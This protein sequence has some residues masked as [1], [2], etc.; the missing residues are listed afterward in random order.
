[1]TTF[2]RSICSRFRRARVGTMRGAQFYGC[3]TSFVVLA[4]VL[5]AC[6]GGPPEASATPTVAQA[7][8]T[9]VAANPTPSAMAQDQAQP[10]RSIDDVEKAVI[11]IEV[12]GSFR[13]IG[14]EQVETGF[15][16]SGFFI[17]GDGLAVTNNH[18]V[19]GASSLR[20]YLEGVDGYR[21]AKVIAVSECSD[22]ALIQ[23]EGKVERYFN[24]YEGPLKTT[25]PIYAAGFPR[26]SERSSKPDGT[27][28]ATNVDGQTDW[29]SIES[30]LEHTANTLPGMSGG[31]VFTRDTIEVVGVNYAGNADNRH[32]AISASLARPLIERLKQGD[33][34]ESIGINGKAFSATTK[35]GDQINGTWIVSV[36]PGT[37]AYKA[38]IKPGDILFS[39]NN[40]TLAQDGTMQD[41][42][43]VL[44]SIKPDAVT[45]ITVYRLDTGELLDGDL[46]GDALVSKGATVQPAVEPTTQ[47]KTAIQPVSLS[48][49]QNQQQLAQHKQ[50]IGTLPR[51][52]KENFENARSLK[53]W[54]QSD[55]DNAQKLVSNVYRLT[56]KQ[57][58]GWN[59]ALWD[60]GAVGNT[61]AIELTV[62]A[63]DGRNGTASV[64]IIFGYDQQGNINI[65]VLR[66][67]HTWEV[68]TYRNNQYLPS[69][70]VEAVADQHIT[71]GVNANTLWVVRTPERVE[72]WINA[73]LVG[74]GPSDMVLAPTVGVIAQSESD[75]TAP[76]S[77]D[78]DNLV[79]RMQ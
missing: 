67:D 68:A 54:P 55:G 4:C 19:T 73:A 10:V 28:S 63:D 75:L 3:I 46:N 47:A 15:V 35:S 76:I 72:F 43:D 70:S 5:S 37:P 20:I 30:V 36:Q 11:R 65:F 21:N 32:F 77:V 33:N 22:L 61:Y 59:P 51:E 8:A 25:L 26:G 57:P 27:I 45:P 49:T 79:V 50:L 17:S 16:G 13:N 78:V 39:M 53:R 41:Y 58:Q 74:V 18:V 64:G 66:N 69:L 42:C 1:M 24:W 71:Q 62:L 44:R 56:M 40:L 2:L 60:Q 31:P 52:F 29:S 9:P 34:I 23:V 48:A 7:A 38:K 6:G 14:E 12:K